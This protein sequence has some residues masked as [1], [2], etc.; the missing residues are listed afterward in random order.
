MCAHQQHM[1]SY[2]V[3]EQEP[4][5][6]FQHGVTLLLKEESFSKSTMDNIF[7]R[8]LFRLLFVSKFIRDG[9]RDG[10]DPKYQDK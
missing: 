7:P 1:G 8:S 5:Q 2:P 3:L 4:H 10:L 9:L 6:I